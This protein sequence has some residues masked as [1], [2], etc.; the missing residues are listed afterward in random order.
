MD[1]FTDS[2]S[3][4]SSLLSISID[5]QVPSQVPSGS[6]AVIACYYDLSGKSLHSLKWYH[7]G[8]EF[9]RVEPRIYPPTQVFSEPGIRVDVS[10]NETLTVISNL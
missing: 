6:N 1:L 7:E 2:H 8:R 9:Y 3:S 5:L 10:T 4:F